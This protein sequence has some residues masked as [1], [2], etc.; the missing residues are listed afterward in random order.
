MANSFF[1]LKFDQEASVWP[2]SSSDRRLSGWN[3][4]TL[5][6]DTC[7][8]PAVGRDKRPSCSLGHDIQHFPFFNKPPDD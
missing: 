6:I 7:F 1:D 2:G 3:P 4:D 5:L 8:D